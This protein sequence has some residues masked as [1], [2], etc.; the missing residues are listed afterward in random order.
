MSKSTIRKC[1][2]CQG[3]EGVELTSYDFA[4]EP[5]KMTM[6]GSDGEI[7]T[8]A[9]NVRVTSNN[10]P[11]E[12]IIDSVVDD[13]AP[14][15]NM[16]YVMDAPPTNLNSIIAERQLSK[17]DSSMNLSTGNQNDLCKKCFHNMVKMLGVYASWEETVEF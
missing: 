5:L 8:I 12:D 11:P 2:V 13:Y 3:R 16:D 9:C 4:T 15:D 7:L 6:N 14:V 1:D 10:P 17:I